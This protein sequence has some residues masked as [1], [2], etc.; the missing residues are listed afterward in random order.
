[1]YSSGQPGGEFKYE[2][3]MMNKRGSHGPTLAE[4]NNT[5]VVDTNSTTNVLDEISMLDD[6]NSIISNDLQGHPSMSTL[7]IEPSSPIAIPRNT[8]VPAAEGKREVT[9]TV[10]VNPSSVSSVS[11]PQQVIHGPQQSVPTP[12]TPAAGT[13]YTVINNVSIPIHVKQE[14]TSSLASQTAAVAVPMPLVQTG[15]SL[16]L[17]TVPVVKATTVSMAPQKPA[18]VPAAATVDWSYPGELSTLDKPSLLKLLS[19]PGLESGLVAVEGQ[20]TGSATPVDMRTMTR[21]PIHVPKRTRGYSEGSGMVHLQREA[22]MMRGL[23]RSGSSES[24][25]SGSGSTSSSFVQKWEELKKYIEDGSNT[26]GVGGGGG[27]G[28]MDMGTNPAKKIK[29]ESQSKDTFDLCY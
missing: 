6:I 7:K 12:Q 14:T 26:G 22:E 11:P 9:H 28:Q 23:K 15:P 2:N 10:S 17:Q 19:S 3:V 16:V 27:G 8:K 29:T 5:S 4:L 13:C 20:A 18:T 25:L 21:R 1:M 24:N